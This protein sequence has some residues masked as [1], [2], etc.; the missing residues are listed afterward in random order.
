[1]KN[2]SL[3]KRLKQSNKQTNNETKINDFALKFSR[4]STNLVSSVGTEIQFQL[5]PTQLQMASARPR[6]Y[7]TKIWVQHH[8]EQLNVVPQGMGVWGFFLLPEEGQPAAQVVVL[9]VE[10]WFC[11]KV[12][13]RCVSRPA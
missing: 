13:F 6:G 8:L 4:F 2:H 10:T 7:L 9:V 5:S 12:S 3:A 11:R 1:M